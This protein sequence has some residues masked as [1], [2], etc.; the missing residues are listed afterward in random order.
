M[1]YIDKYLVKI[2]NNTQNKQIN[3]FKKCINLRAN[4][5][6]QIIP[7]PHKQKTLFQKYPKPHFLGY[8]KTTSWLPRKNTQNTAK[9][10]NNSQ[11]TKF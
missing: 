10:Q 6:P 8:H 4:E 9:Y 7:T 1:Y 3:G 11:T 2:H 5:L